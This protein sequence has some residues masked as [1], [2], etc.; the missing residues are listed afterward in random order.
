MRLLSFGS[1]ALIAAALMQPA[2]SQPIRSAPEPTYADLADIALTAPVAAHVEIRRARALRE[3]DSPGVAPDARRFLVEANVLGLIR[4][5]GGLPERVRYLVDLPNDARGRAA[6][7]RR[8]EQFLVLAAPVR[9]ETDELRLAGPD[10]HIPYSPVAADRLRAIIA[11][12]VRPDAPPR[13]AGIGRAF[14]VPG[15]LPGE[16]E[17]QIFLVT[18]DEQPVSL[19]VLRRPGERPRWAVA[20]SEIVD[21]SAGPPEPETLLWYRLA[22][23][24]PRS[25]PPQALRE[26]GRAE[27]RAIEA[28]YALVLE[29]LGPCPRSRPPG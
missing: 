22:C 26:A 10:A 25:L 3:E 5:A 2:D 8:G 20:M 15:T 12:A 27:A 14:H 9:G 4:G 11:E 18:A 7:L 6:R 16:S 28:D 17:T 13:I 21:R 24:L 29:R 23:F 19:T 1:A